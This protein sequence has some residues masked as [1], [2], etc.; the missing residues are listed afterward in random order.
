M[1]RESHRGGPMMDYF[2][3]AKDLTRLQV[4][5]RSTGRLCAFCE[6][7]RAYEKEAWHLPCCD[8]CY[9]MIA[10]DMERVLE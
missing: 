10:D 8:T 5:M 7:S 6:L 1:T 2:S 3:L 4:T 9:Q